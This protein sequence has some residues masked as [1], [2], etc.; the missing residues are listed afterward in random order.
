MRPALHWG[1]RALLVASLADCS[2]CLTC[3]ADGEERAKDSCC[4]SGRGHIA[5]YAGRQACFCGIA[6]K[7]N[8]GHVKAQERQCSGK[9]ACANSGCG[10]PPAP[11]DQVA[12][13]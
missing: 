5:V 10:D 8:G 4:F 12:S 13:A 3:Q 9:R 11:A 6:V 2:N 7:D 1:L